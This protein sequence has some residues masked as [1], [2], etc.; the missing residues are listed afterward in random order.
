[1][2]IFQ[3]FENFESEN[4]KNFIK[5]GY[6]VTKCENL[7]GLHE[8]RDKT[9]KILHELTDD[10][11]NNK[12]F[13]LDRAHLS[14]NKREVNEIRMA[15]YSRLNSY[16]W[17]RPTYFSFARTIVEDIIGRELVMQNRINCNI[18]MPNDE[19]SNIYPHIDSHSGESP[20]QCVLWIPLTDCHDSNSICILPPK[21]NHV[22][23]NNFKRCMKDG[24]REEF[25]K[26]VEDK[27]IWVN[28]P[29][30]YCILFTPT[31]LHGSVVNKTKETRW[32]FNTRFKALFTPYY[33]QEKGLG[34]FYLPIRTAPATY[35]GLKYS[36]PIGMEGK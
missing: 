28:V 7:K 17:F 29:Y 23:L 16:D 36:P 33:S 19:G 12:D 9:I 30:G 31:L 20:F 14:L 1:M 4:S 35:F 2:S 26:K 11:Y 10:K 27:L 5:N 13:S 18:M 22:A 32:S 21:D 8:L 25:F 24:G 15:I 6:L 3:S 34:S